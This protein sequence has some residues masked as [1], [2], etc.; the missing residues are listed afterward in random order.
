MPESTEDIARR[1][2]SEMTPSEKVGQLFIVRPE[3]LATPNS[4]LS[5]SYKSVSSMSDTMRANFA[6]YPV[7]G[8]ALF[9][10]NILTPAQTAAFNRELLNVC[11][12]PLFIAVDEEGGRVARLANNS[13]F[14]LKKYESAAAVGASGD[15]SAALEMG[16]TIGNYLSQYGFNMDFAPDADVFTN[17]NN[18]VIGNRAFSSDAYTAAKMAAAM[19]KGLRNNNIIPVYKHFPGHGDTSED[20]HTGAAYANKTH[21]EMLTCEW[22]PF[23]E[24]GSL[25][26]VMAGHISAPQI[27]GSNVPA[28]MSGQMITQ[29]LRGE[30]GFDGLVITDALAMG[31]VTKV[32]NAKSAAVNA[33]LAG[34]DI[35]LLPDNLG[36]SFDGVLSAVND[37]TITESRLDE[38]VM[39]IL[40][41]K[42][43][44]GIIKA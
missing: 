20:S 28:T 43:K 36:A 10:D 34:C 19:A 12:I 17:P 15:T 35:L 16:N 38:S 24:A 8:V 32:Y 33:I 11:D 6:K 1:L 37:G 13:A 2:L 31:A 39:R 44:Y 41:Y 9:A 4:N 25:D 29:I 7:G 3:A 18:T 26:G 40:I 21:D 22:L 14:G 23:M 27:T 30:L 5:T 42:L